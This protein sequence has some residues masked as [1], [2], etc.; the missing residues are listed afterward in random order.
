[1]TL[2]CKCGGKIVKLRCAKCGATYQSEAQAYGSL[3]QDNLTAA[4][5][6]LA[7]ATTDKTQYVN[8]LGEAIAHLRR[9][10]RAL[11]EMERSHE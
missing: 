5:D 2:P 10:E 9:A 3:F 4:T 6:A 11:Q 8:A 1:M 7:S